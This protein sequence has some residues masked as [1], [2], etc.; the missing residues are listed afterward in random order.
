MP[1]WKRHIVERLS[2]LRLAP[3]RE[4]E[5]VEELSQHLDERWRELTAGGAS[6]EEATRLAL[7][8]FSEENLLARY[9]APLRQS[10]TP[11]SITPGS[12]TGHLLS[13]LWLDLR[14]AARTLT[15]R[16]SFAIAAVSTLALGI[17]ANTALF[18]FVDGVLLKPLPYPEPERLVQVWEKP[19]GFQRNGIASLNFMD[20][21]KQNRVFS[22]MTALSG[23]AYTWT[24]PG[25]AGEPQRLRAS[26][27]S[28]AYWDVL[29]VKPAL[30][31]GFA[32][33]EDQPGKDKVVI[34]SHRTWQAKFHGDPQILDRTILLDGEPFRIAGV[35]ARDT[36]FDRGFNDLWRPLCLLCRGPQRNFHWLNA[37][38]RLK[39]G[40]TIEQ[41]RAEMDI[42]A[43][44][45][46]ETYPKDKKGWGVTID[47]WMDRIVSEQLRQSLTVLMCAVGALLLIACSN[48]ANLML[49]RNAARSREM[50]V[51]M[52]LGASR[53]RL[54]RLMLLENLLLSLAG[55][56]LGIALG[57]GLMRIIET[58]L[59]PF[60]L[61]SER[62]VSLDLRVLGFTLFV[63]LTTGLVFGLL[64][65]WTSARG[66]AAALR[67]GGRGETGG[68][69]RNAV[70]NGLIVAE[71]ALALILVTC[72]GLL[73]SSFF[74]LMQVD[75]GFDSSNAI[76]M[77]V[78]MALGKDTNGTQLTLYLEQIEASLRALPGVREAAFACGVPMRGACG[79]MPFRIAGRAPGPN[80]SRQA[81]P[82][83]IVTPSYFAAAGLRIRKGRPLLAQDA[84]GAMPAMLVNERFVERMF[85]GEEAIGKQVMVEEIVTGKRELGPEIPW[86]I[87]GVVANEKIGGLDSDAAVM[88]VP[89]AQS[90]SLGMSLLVRSVGDPKL[91]QNTIQRAIWTINKNQALTNVETLEEIKN[92]SMASNRLRT[93]LI[94][95]FAVLALV[96][97]IIGVYGV[98]SYT[99]EQRRREIGIRAALGAKP[100]SLVGLMVGQGM[101]VVAIGL[102][103]G[104]AG[105]YGAGRVLEGLLFRTEP[106][107]P[108]IFL[109][110]LAT[111]SLTALAAC[112]APARRAAQVDPNIVLRYE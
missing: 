90:P 106:F 103:A 88:Y 57:F 56:L 84:K 1:D 63:T 86:Q 51:R 60:S 70:R 13:D 12:A 82:F 28:A 104:M 108:Q 22:H 110:A 58:S 92:Q 9:M 87:V 23:E 54:I 48:V 3:T 34:L 100:G 25:D 93:G 95:S 102:A 8:D 36:N 77:N 96:L 97:A 24:Q 32:A 89:F 18:S 41:A 109:V 33:D 5:I 47:L 35:T 40:V 6:P 50:N 55:G 26:L 98:I 61:P 49:T 17:G 99:V 111:L 105:A 91:M 72:G 53:G 10:H 81:A 30:G 101:L 112:Y 21:Q 44:T 76:A 2:S 19:P 43:K 39:P 66:T 74:R 65:A 52:A 31:R 69:G 38:A 29:G 85:P 78:P 68:R 14:Y 59:P 16:P 64:P 20:W 42:I 37:L 15:K 75:P 79:G 94:A 71:V 11:A 73:T 80:A 45:I 67:D 27:V 83:K 107:E 46:A 7:A 4:A 62:T